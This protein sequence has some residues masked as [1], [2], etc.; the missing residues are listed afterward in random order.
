MNPA[1]V[2]CLMM[3]IID[4][5]DLTQS[6]IG[7]LVEAL[8]SDQVLHARNGNKLRVAEEDAE[9]VR[10]AVAVF[11]RHNAS[12]PGQSESAG[13][14]GDVGHARY[15]VSE[16]EPLARQFMIREL[17]AR[18]IQFQIEAGVLAVRTHDE[19]DVDAIIAESE[20]RVANLEAHQTLVREIDG[21]LRAPSCDVC[22]ASPAAPIDLRRQVGMVL[23][24]KSYRAQATLCERCADEAYRQFQKSTAIKGWTGVRSAIMNPI[25]LATNAY[26]RYKHKKQINE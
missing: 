24:M 13:R 10:I 3:A 8:N 16:M 9:A 1:W 23:V 2:W 22:G 4:L 21:G 26:N 5:A 6:Q 12:Q 14:G 20:S 7:E 25:V 17:D 18:K 15:D 11:R 19:S